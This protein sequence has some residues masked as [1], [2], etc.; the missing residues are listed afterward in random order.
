MTAAGPAGRGGGVGECLT[1][2]AGRS[3]REALAWIQEDT[4]AAL[5]AVRQ[6]E[7]HA[8]TRPE[9]LA[10]PASATPTSLAA[11]EAE[12]FPDGRTSSPLDDRE[13]R[14]VEAAFSTYMAAKV[15]A[16]ADRGRQGICGLD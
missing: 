5:N 7:A 14:R 16:S 9:K 3:V 4:N 6:A 1:D 12:A 2:A 10:R 11:L 8:R 15:V 13:R